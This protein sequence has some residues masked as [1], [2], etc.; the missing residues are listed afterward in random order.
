ML[1]LPRRGFAAEG[2]IRFVGRGWGLPTWL[3]RPRPPSTWH[4]RQTVC[5]T[6]ETCRVLADAVRLGCRV[7]SAARYRTCVCICVNIVMLTETEHVRVGEQRHSIVTLSR[8]GDLSP[9]PVKLTSARVKQYHPRRRRSEP[10]HT[11]MCVFATLPDDRVEL[12]SAVRFR[13]FYPPNPYRPARKPRRSYSTALRSSILYNIIILFFC[14]FYSLYVGIPIVRRLLPDPSSAY[15]SGR[16]YIMC[17][18]SDKI[19]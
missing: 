5:A 16:A 4:R 6:W 13:S 11:W 15:R 17:I 14:R 9:E 7:V 3:L 10:R 2:R 8:R 19:P 12:R 1:S 18:Y